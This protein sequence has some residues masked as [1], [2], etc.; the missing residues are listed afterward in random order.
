MPLQ[1][2]YPVDLEKEDLIFLLESYEERLS[3]KADLIEGK[4]NE[5]QELQNEANILHEKIVKIKEQMSPFNIG[6]A[7][8]SY[9]ID[10]TWND[11]IKYVL[12]DAHRPLSTTEIVDIIKQMHQPTWERTKLMTSVS[13]TISAA[14]GELYKKTDNGITLI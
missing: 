4:K 12:K 3:A 6:M 14:M 7:R 9:P 5:L 1:V 11:K 8:M 13:A 10:G 2:T